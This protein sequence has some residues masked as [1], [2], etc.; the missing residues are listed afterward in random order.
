MYRTAIIATS[1][2]TVAVHTFTSLKAIYVASI[3]ETKAKFNYK[4]FDFLH[5]V[6]AK[7]GS[8][9]MTTPL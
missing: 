3:L 9:H 6:F 5:L 7:K 8:C 4:L 1:V 2:M